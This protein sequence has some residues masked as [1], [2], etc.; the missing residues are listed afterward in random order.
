MQ[1]VTYQL[2]ETIVQQLDLLY[3]LS[4]DYNAHD[5]YFTSVFQKVAILIKS[6]SELAQTPLL[7][8]NGNTS[9]ESTKIIENTY[10]VLNT[11]L[12]HV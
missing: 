9:A 5:E 8:D 7:D 3:P 6:M 4:V 10:S 1:E 11:E 2:E 12:A